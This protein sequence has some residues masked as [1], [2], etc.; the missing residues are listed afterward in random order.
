MI[1][2]VLTRSLCVIDVVPAPIWGAA[3]YH[4]EDLD[5]VVWLMNAALVHLHSFV[6]LP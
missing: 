1:K 3:A 6:L 5:L 2:F 4:L